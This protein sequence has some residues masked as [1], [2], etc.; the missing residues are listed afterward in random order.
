MHGVMLLM[1]TFDLVYEGLTEA[2]FEDIKEEIKLVYEDGSDKHQHRATAEI[3]GALMAGVMDEPIEDRN[4]VWDYAVPIMQK[5]FADGLTPENLAYWM[6]CLHLV[7]GSKDPRRSRE[8]VD[9]LAAFKLD[10][11]SNAAFKESSKIQLL[12]FAVADAG[13]HFRMEKP[14]VQDFIEHLDHPYKSVREAIGRT[15]ATIFRTRYYEAFKDVDTLLEANKAA[16]SIGIKPYQPTKE[17]ATTIKGVFDQLEIWRK[18]RTP[19]QQTPSAYTSASKT[20]MLWLDTTLNS[21][22]C[23]ELLDFFPDVF[24]EQLLHMMDVKE[25][26]ELQR[27]AYH[28]YRHLPNIPFRSGEDSDFISALIRIGKT[29][30]SWHQR[31]RTLINMQVIY[32]RRIF[33]IRPAEQTALIDAVADMLEDTQL[34]VRMGASTTLAGMIRCSPVVLRENILKTL[35]IKFTKSLA[36]N[37]M[38]KKT[39]GT[40]TPTS[41]SKQITRRHAAV[42]GLGALVQAFPYQTPPPEWMPEILA[43]LASRAASDAGAIGKTVKTVLADFKKTRQDTWVTDQKVCLFLWQYFRRRLTFYPV[44]HP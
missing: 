26:P 43:M 6:T 8:I 29:S 34:E 2:T 20:V 32:F 11:S 36:K 15:L 35:Q 16:S 41:H 17:F 25:D 24:M 1:H 3:V 18:E 4:R 21:Y 5:V 28:V 30:S 37:P 38:P 31:L 19:G 39:P 27:L 23:T 10:M 40:D 44:F 9:K 14:I 7:T 13:W 12:E 22:E 33:L 42:L